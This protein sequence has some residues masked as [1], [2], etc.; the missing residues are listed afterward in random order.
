MFN[1]L[2]EMVR[3]CCISDIIEMW[4]VVGLFDVWY[5]I[6]NMI[7]Y[8]CVCLCVYKYIWFSLC[9]GYLYNIKR[10]RIP[11]PDVLVWKI[12]RCRTSEKLEK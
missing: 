5:I 12:I 8:M 3:K 9:I 4:V 7:V 2:R 6:G 1:I 10:Y 11:Y